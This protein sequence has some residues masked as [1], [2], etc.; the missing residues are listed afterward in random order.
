[1]NKKYKA[2]N[3]LLLNSV[4]VA[5]ASITLGVISVDSSGIL[6]S[7]GWY[8]KTFYV[9]LTGGTYFVYSLVIVG[10][11]FLILKLFR[12]NYLIPMAAALFD[13]LVIVYL[14]ADTFVYP[15]YRTHLNLAM[16]QMTFFGGGRIVSFSLPM[17]VEIISYLVV[18][19]TVIAFFF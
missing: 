18:I 8:Q 7:W 5:I 11:L 16:L 6:G 9:A 10:L 13:F 1:M 3:Q 15:M 2:C 12:L 4:F 19:S 14:A 17:I